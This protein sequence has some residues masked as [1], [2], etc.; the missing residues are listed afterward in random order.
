MS[1]CSTKIF[2]HGGEVVLRSEIGFDRKSTVQWYWINSYYD[3]LVD[4]QK[5][6]FKE[7]ELTEIDKTCYLFNKLEGMFKGRVK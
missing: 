4:L 7:D 3:K 2:Y 5:E 1:V 6:I